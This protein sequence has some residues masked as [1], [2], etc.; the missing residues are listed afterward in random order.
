MYICIYSSTDEPLKDKMHLLL[1]WVG[2]LV[3]LHTFVFS[4]ITSVVKLVHIFMARS[5][6]YKSRLKYRVCFYRYV[7]FGCVPIYIYIY[8]YIYTYISIYT[9]F[10]I[11]VNIKEELA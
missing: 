3:T 5:R 6:V 4:H 9:N 7:H 2:L 1:L 8:I 11:Y 10:Y